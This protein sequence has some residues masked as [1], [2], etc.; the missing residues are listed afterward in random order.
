MKT[1]VYEKVNPDH[2]AVAGMTPEQIESYV[3]IGIAACNCE[4]IKSTR[5]F[6]VYNPTGWGMDDDGEFTA[7]AMS[8]AGGNYGGVTVEE[9]LLMVYEEECMTAV[10]PQTGCAETVDRPKC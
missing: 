6:T 3:R 2:S 10:Q 4:Q 7:S 9:V 8:K 1:I 5:P